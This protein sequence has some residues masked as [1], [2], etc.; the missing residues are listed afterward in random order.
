[1]SMFCDAVHAIRMESPEL[2][3]C[4]ILARVSLCPPHSQTARKNACRS[5]TGGAEKVWSAKFPE[6]NSKLSLQLVVL[7]QIG[8]KG[9]NM[10]SPNNYQV[11]FQPSLSLPLSLCLSLCLTLSLPLPL[12]LFLF[13]SVHGVPGNGVYTS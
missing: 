5:V 13:N 12:P 8:C 4:T 11:C 1:M 3:F 2:F 6:Y 10:Y 9:S 7:L